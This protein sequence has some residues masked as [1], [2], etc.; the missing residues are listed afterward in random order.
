MRAVAGQNRNVS[1]SENL[2]PT[3]R[4]TSILTV[5]GAAVVF[6]VVIGVVSEAHAY[7][8]WLA[9]ALAG[10]VIAALIAQLATQRKEGFVDRLAAS[11]VGAFVIL[12]L[13][14]GVVALVAAVR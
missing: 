5:W 1:E 13:A 8:S 10:C 9:L 12:G 3:L 11:V 2:A 7:A 14:G 4:W 6:A